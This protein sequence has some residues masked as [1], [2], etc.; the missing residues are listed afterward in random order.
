MYMR[1]FAKRYQVYLDPHSVAVLDDLERLTQV[2]RSKWIRE[3]VGRFASEV[4]KV[5][6]Q[7][8]PEKPKKYHLD[9][10]VG[11]IKVKG[12]KKT[13]YAMHVDNIYLRD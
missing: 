3:I 2:S 13:N 12:K 5:I 1:T 4:A 6:A 7:V 9:E 10:L 8:K 11:F